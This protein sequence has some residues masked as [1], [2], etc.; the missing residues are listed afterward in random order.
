M[1]AAAEGVSSHSL[2]TSPAINTPPR[3]PHT[4]GRSVVLDQAPS[5]STRSKTKAATASTTLIDQDPAGVKPPVLKRARSATKSPYFAIKKEPSPKK[6]PSPRKNVSCIPFPPLSS[7]SFGLAQERLAQNPFHLLLACIFL[8]KTRGAVAMPVFY[9]LIDQYP[10]PQKLAKAELDD[11]VAIFQHLGLQ[12][13][14]AKKVCG[15]ARTWCEFPPVKGRRYRCLHYPLKG[16]GRDIKPNECIPHEDERVAW[17][18]AHFPGLGAYAF[19][20]WRIFCRDALR[21]LAHVDEM[22]GEWT[23]VL[24]MDKEL[25]AYL[26][27]R[28]LRNGWVWD[29]VTGEKR[30]AEPTELDSAGKGGVI[31]EGD[32][33]GKVVGK[34]VEG[35]DGIGRV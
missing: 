17:E 29:P 5:A 30:R 11:I 22:D 19:D 13:Q 35:S 14:R 20:S 10:T 6:A 26:R 25:R 33:G 31:V 18:V 16:D 32:A 23:R 2:T 24:P 8:N 3:P 34:K 28:W 7:P 27:W 1:T 21:G 12:N 4:P 9:D 15:L